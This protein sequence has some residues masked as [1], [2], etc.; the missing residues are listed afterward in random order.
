[1]T[2]LAVAPSDY[3]HVPAGL[4]AVRDRIDA[5]CIAAGRAADAVTLVA[6]S[7]THPVEAVI[8]ALM[9]FVPAPHE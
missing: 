3:S 7:K 8:A 6:V 1:M 9:Y 2:D 5:A 4:R